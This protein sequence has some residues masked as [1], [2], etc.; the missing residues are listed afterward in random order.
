MNKTKI[1]AMVSRLSLKTQLVVLILTSFTILIAMIIIYM[2]I[3]NSKTI[4]DQQKSKLST[5]LALENQNLDSYFSELDR[6]SLLMRYDTGFLNLIESHS[7]LSYSNQLEVQNLLRSNFTSRTDLYAYKL[8]LIN[9]KTTY[10]INAARRKIL[11]YPA[12]DIGSLP[13]YDRFTQGKYYKLILPSESP[14]QFLTYYRTIIDVS[15]QS[16]LAIIELS[17]DLSYID[18]LTDAFYDRNET[19]FLFDGEGQLIYGTNMELFKKHQLIETLSNLKRTKNGSITLV[20]NDV[21]YLVIYN[22]SQRNGQQLL[23]FKPVADIEAQLVQ[24]RNVAFILGFLAISVTA[25][26]ALV[27]IG[28][29]TKPLHTLAVRLQGVGSGNFSATVDVSGS[30]E[31]AALVQDYNA[32]IYEI[33]NLIK[34]NYVT[35]LNEKTAR[36]AALEAQLNPHFLYNTLQ[37]IS[38]EAIIN[39]QQNIN[40]MVTALASMLR[41][42]IKGGD[43]VPLSDEIKHVKDYL[44]LQKARFEEN[45]TY[46]LYIADNT[47]KYLIPKISIQSLVENSINHGMKGD[48]MAI[49]IAVRCKM[50]GD[51]VYIMVTDNGQGMDEERLTELTQTFTRNPVSKEAANHIGLLNLYSRL[52]IL[53][54]NEASL[55][56]RSIPGK[57]T[58]ITMII[59]ITK[60][61]NY[62]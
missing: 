49:H 52:Q 31:I 55:E 22:E 41:Y 39:D 40:Y 42:T 27:F 43:L 32:M 35:E 16:P 37:A 60:E 15:D 5:L 51:M 50:Y 17:V 53:Y 20:F 56:L 46:D 38:S 28:I 48:V 23:L 3:N 34:K 8:Y 4:I 14:D 9:Q 45:L 47:L 33:D 19:T 61:F 11:T 59:P 21:E 1:K 44:L 58:T 30:S 12:E 10:E 13:G 62:V 36:L 25:F 2:Y 57:E 26:V 7:D 18:E 54:N 29:L 6:F 24:T